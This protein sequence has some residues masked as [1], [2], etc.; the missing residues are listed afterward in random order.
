[1]PL[2]L[3]SNIRS[4]LTFFDFPLACTYDSV[5]SALISK[6]FHEISIELFISMGESV[7]SFISIYLDYKFSELVSTIYYKFNFIFFYLNYN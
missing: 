4:V 7:L 6:F 2:T 5:I 3:L 1:M